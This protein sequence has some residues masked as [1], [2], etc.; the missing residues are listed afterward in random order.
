MKLILNPVVI[1]LNLLMKIGDFVLLLINFLSA[2]IYLPVKALGLEFKQIKK[3]AGQETQ[4]L[5]GRYAFRKNKILQSKQSIKFSFPKIKP[6]LPKI[7][8]IQFKF[9]TF[10]PEF[11]KS[12]PKPKRIKKIKTTVVYKKPHLIR[13]RIK[14]FIFGGFFSFVLIFLPILFLIFLQNLPNP[15]ELSLREISQTTKIYDRNGFLL[16]QIFANENR[17]LVPLSSVPNDLVNATI[18]IEDKDFYKNH[19][20]D[21]NAIIRAA[22]ADVSGKPIQGGSTITQQLIKSTLLTPEVSVGRKIKEIIL[23]V[24]TEKTYTKNEILQMYFNQVPYGGTAW[25]VEAASEVYFGKNVKDLDLAQSAFL[26][27]MP[28]APTTY[29]PY[30]ENPNLWKERQKEVL[31]KMLEQGYITQTQLENS[32]NEQ[33]S[34]LPSQTPIYAAH[35]VMYVKDLLV[36]KYGLPLVEKGGLSVITS[37][38]LKLQDET[39]NIVKTEVDNDAYLHLTNGAALITNP[40]N[41]DILAMVG[42]RDY[43]DP[44]GG[45]VNLTTSLRQPG[46]SIKVVTYATALSNGFTAATILDDS[47]VTYTSP[48]AP[49]YSPV[50]YDGAFHGKVPLRLAFANSFNIPAVKTLQKVGISNMVGM[51]KKMGISTWGDPSQYGLSITL[52][53]AEVKMT[54]MAQVYGTIANSGKEVNLDPILKITDYQENLIY[55]K[56][57]PEEKSVIDEGV[58]F[59]IA[60]ILSDN[61]ARSLEFGIN[62]PLNIPNHN[63]SVKTGTSDNKRDNW[64]IGFTPSRLVAVWVG[65]NDNSPMSQTL[66]SGITG[67]APIWNKVM[68][69]LLGNVSDTPLT[70]PADIIQKPCL[71]RIEYFVKGTENSVSCKTTPTPS[72]SP[73]T[74]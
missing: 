41:G 42:S 24:W 58:A 71:G 47:P 31:Q 13:L 48:G 62:S 18:A 44:N 29:S 63:V 49:A 27:G 66:A 8:K 2:I 55:Q 70:I 53:A 65:N 23:A 19:G 10:K 67:A 34:F 45:N 38:D 6:T 28:Q 4:S 40:K 74:N 68:T 25:G 52:G 14:Y 73:T 1:I 59:I 15:K 11:L 36:K 64:T 37:L 60:N 16:Y 12:K 32:L 46:S 35:F 21:T 39:Q 9:P 61:L 20:F 69:M 7:P 43:N 30:G 54:D 5:S 3:T 57:A 51:G 22:V 17:T 50:N 33:L 56:N 26:A 72:A